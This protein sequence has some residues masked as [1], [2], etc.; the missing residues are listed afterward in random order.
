[1]FDTLFD[2]TWHEG[3]LFAQRM[4]RMWLAS[5]IREINYIRTSSD[6]AKLFSCTYNK[7]FCE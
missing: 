5:T 1:M 3:T 4:V 2:L 7:R 6:E